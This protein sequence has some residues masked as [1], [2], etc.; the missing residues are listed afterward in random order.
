MNFT[1]LTK[2]QGNSVTF[3]QFELTTIVEMLKMQRVN[4]LDESQW[5]EHKPPPDGNWKQNYLKVGNPGSN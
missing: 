4:V 3:L 1:L 2:I 5:R